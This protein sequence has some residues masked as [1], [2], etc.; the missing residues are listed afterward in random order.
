MS[1]KNKYILYTDGGFSLKNE[2]GSAAYCIVQIQPNGKEYLVQE[3]SKLIYNCKSSAESELKA[4]LMGLQY[5][6]EYYSYEE[7]G[8]KI[9]TDSNFCRDALIKWHYSWAKNGWKTSTGQPVKNRW[10]ILDIL[11]I[12]GNLKYCNIKSIKSRSQ[13]HNIHVD[14]MATM[15]LEEAMLNCELC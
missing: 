11:S 2:I 7:T 15:C 5:F 1:E 3:D 9:I 10:V 6:E 4:I 12:M 14:D 13:E 8:I